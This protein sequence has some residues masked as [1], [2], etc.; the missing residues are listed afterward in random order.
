MAAATKGCESD[1]I[2]QRDLNDET[3]SSV[4]GPGGCHVCSIGFRYIDACL[5][6]DP[7]LAWPTVHV[8]VQ[9]SFV[10]LSD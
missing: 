2:L 3:A 6:V 7:E 10:R 1:E 5:I 9:R 4:L 8:A